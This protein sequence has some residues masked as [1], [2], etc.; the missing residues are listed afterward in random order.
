MPCEMTSPDGE[1]LSIVREL[2]F[3]HHS[4]TSGAVVRDNRTRH[5]E[6]FIKGSYEKIK[7]LAMPQTVPA[8]YDQ[9]TMQC[10]KQNYYTLGISYKDLGPN[11][12]DDQVRSMPREQLEHDVSV[13][14]LLLFRNEMKADSPDAIQSLKEGSVRSVICTGDNA[15]QGPLGP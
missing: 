3:D 14:G 12:T 13:C 4:M 6:V 9:V 2:E 7:A 5:L 15:T 11:I 8:N 1:V 10:A